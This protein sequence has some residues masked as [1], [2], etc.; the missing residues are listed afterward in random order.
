LT[1]STFVSELKAI[2]GTHGVAPHRIEVEFTE[3][4]LRLNARRAKLAIRELHTAGFTV[5]LDDFG[6]GYASV[7]YLKEFA[8]DRIKLDRSMTHNVSYAPDKQKV[9][10]GTILIAQ[11]LSADIIAEGIESEEEAKL[12]RLAG[13]QHMQGYYFARPQSFETLRLLVPARKPRSSKS[14]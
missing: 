12:M 13:C 6:T 4:I 2:A 11:G 5:A 9:V 1:S 3:T 14:A 7:S 10:H 8:F